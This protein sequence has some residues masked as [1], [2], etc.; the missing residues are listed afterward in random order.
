MK[1]C[2]EVKI[3][4]ITVRVSILFVVVFFVSSS[5]TVQLSMESTCIVPLELRR[6]LDS[7]W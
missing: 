5:V 6:A 4:E 3:L 2:H 1:L 7:T